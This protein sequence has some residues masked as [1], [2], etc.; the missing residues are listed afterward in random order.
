[1]KLL[2]IVKKVGSGLVREMV[3][4]GG[5]LISA[6]NALLPRGTNLPDN[7]TGDDINVAI[8]AL[9]ATKQASVM[10]KEFDVEITEIKESHSTLRTMLET[11]ANNPHSTRPYIAKGAFYV[12]AFVIILV[13]GVWAYGAITGHVEMV[14]EIMSG[15]PF[16]LAIIGPFVTLLW[17]YFGILK[18]EHRG[19]LNAAN[20][21]QAHGGIASLLSSFINR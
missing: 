19:K 14:V 4:G 7:A 9:P 13:M 20:G 21:L 15:G 10:E 3:P 8:Q 6:V 5:L 1:M 2:D 16:I 12:V 18:S 17:A 11:D